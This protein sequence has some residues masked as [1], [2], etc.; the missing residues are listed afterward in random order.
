MSIHESPDMMMNFQ[1]KN[2]IRPSIPKIMIPQVIF[3]D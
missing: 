2:T 1:S 3:K